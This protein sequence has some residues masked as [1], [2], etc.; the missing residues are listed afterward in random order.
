MAQ[1][2]DA[3][4]EEST[5][6]FPKAV[7]EAAQAEL[8][9]ETYVQVEVKNVGLFV[10]IKGP[11][12]VMLSQVFDVRDEEPSRR[13]LVIEPARGGKYTYWYRGID[14]TVEGVTLRGLSRKD[15][16]FRD[17][18]DGQVYALEKGDPLPSGEGVEI[19][20]TFSWKK[21]DV[22]YF[23]EMDG[24]KEKR[25]WKWVGPLVR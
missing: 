25:V 12:K 14:L 5:V 4:A 16:K 8:S 17:D 24:R 7:Q 22:V 6:G 19:H 3:A 11:A 20:G 23:H 18:H 9:P 21:E 13:V 1:V 15:Q 10:H 2:L